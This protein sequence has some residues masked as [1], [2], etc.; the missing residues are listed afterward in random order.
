MSEVDE[1]ELEISEVSDPNIEELGMS[2]LNV[3]HVLVY[4]FA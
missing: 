1:N 2:Y 3:F 4:L